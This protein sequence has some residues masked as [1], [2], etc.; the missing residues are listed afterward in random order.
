MPKKSEKSLV[1]RRPRLYLEINGRQFC[2]G[3]ETKIMGILNITP[4]SFSDGGSFL[5]PR[6]AACRALEME[7]EGAHF[8]DIGGESSRPGSRPVTAKEE[9]KRI[10]PVLKILSKKLK[11]PMSVDTYKYEVAQAALDQGAILINDIYGLRRDRRLAKL[12]ARYKAGVVLMHMQ[13][14]PATMQKKPRYRNAVQ[15]IRKCLERSVA[16]ALDGGISR[17]SIAIDPGFG[18]GKTTEQNL[19]ILG[20]LR[21]FLSLRRPI[22]V[23]LSRKSFI[24]NVLNAPVGERLSGSLAAAALAIIGGAH[25]LRV[26]DVLPHKQLAAII[27]G[28]LEHSLN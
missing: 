18:F 1:C 12:I 13:G 11:I 28:T 16:L 15:E 5:D 2:L 24:G 3:S 17:S 6:A 8:I 7:R 9:I 27:D 10:Q 20:G 14:R 21:G 19:E 23:G 22:L 26:H 25:I 4:D